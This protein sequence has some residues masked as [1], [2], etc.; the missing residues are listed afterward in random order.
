MRPRPSEPGVPS[1]DRRDCLHCPFLFEERSTGHPPA[2]TPHSFLLVGTRRPQA[3]TQACCGCSR[4][5]RQEPLLCTLEPSVP[6]AP[7]GRD[8]EGGKGGHAHLAPSGR[9]IFTVRESMTCSSNTW[10]TS[11]I[12]SAYWSPKGRADTAVSGSCAPFQQVL[13][14]RP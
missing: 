9:M 7:R 8:Q 5:N 10:S 1:P 3:I 6:K 14:P 4:L 13:E 2:S 11:L 12:F